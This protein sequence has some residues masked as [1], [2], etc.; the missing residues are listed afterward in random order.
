MKKIT[1]NPLYLYFILLLSVL[2]SCQQRSQ[3]QTNPALPNVVLLLGDDHGWDET[4]YNGHPY[5]QTPVLDEMAAAGLRMNRF[6]SASP[7]CSPTRGSII[8]G[9]H[10]NRYGTFTPGYSI[11]PEEISIAS[12][13]KDAG[14]TTAH[15]GKWHLGPVKTG[16]PTNP[17]ALGFE[18]YISHDNFFEMDPPL[19]VNGAEPVIF[20]GESSEILVR[21]AQ[22]FM[23]K[24]MEKNE[25]FFVVIWYGSPHEPYSGT[26][27]DLALYEDLPEN[28]GDRMV[29][30]TSNETGSR[31]ER[32][33]RNVLQERFAEITAMDRSIGQLR[34]YLEEKGQRSNTLLWYFGDNGTPQEA[35]AT[36]PFRGQKGDVYEGG[37]RVP[38]VLEWPA[39][40]KQPIVSDANAV[41]SDVMPTL[42]DIIGA[43]LP[44][45]PIDGISLLPMMENRMPQRPAPIAFWN[46]RPRN[47]GEGLEDYIDPELQKGTTPLVKL[48]GGIATRNFKNFHQTDIREEDFSGPRALLDNQYKLVIHGGTGEDAKR[49]LF[50]IRS[51]PAEEK[52]LIDTQAEIAGNMEDQLRSWQQSVL[53]SLTESDYQ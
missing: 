25:P 39:K 20:E 16:S 40:I 36:V 53:E 29:N 4:G 2:I 38:A 32:L 34:D 33:Q 30:L 5:L 42:L 43:D 31:V 35:N 51:D 44:E 37:I 48:M 22:K 49:E 26:P 46:G 9:R 45:L 50:D 27:E 15:Y 47:A 19:S 52:N 6:Y 21:E 18:E 12:L 28:F 8:T 23:D 14:Y 3:E 24:A 1:Q 13:M 41:S 10:P 17:A 7:V 11:R